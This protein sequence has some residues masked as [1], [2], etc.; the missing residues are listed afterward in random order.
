MDDRHGAR[1][2]PVGPICCRWRNSSNFVSPDRVRSGAWGAGAGRLLRQPLRAS[3]DSRRGDLIKKNSRSSFA[4]AA[5]ALART[6]S[7]GFK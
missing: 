4:R 5:A 1:A 2:G 7:I 3:L 6:K